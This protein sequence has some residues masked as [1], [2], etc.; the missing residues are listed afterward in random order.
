[1]GEL[2]TK[3]EN[4]NGILVV[5]SRVIAKQL[6]KRHEKV[7]RDLDKILISPHLGRLKIALYGVRYEKS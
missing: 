2:I 3:I 5:S 1:M 6:G 4:V 7:L